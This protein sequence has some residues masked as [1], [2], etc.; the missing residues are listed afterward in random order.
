MLG[1][2]DN[3]KKL[4]ADPKALGRWGEQQAEKL[5]KCKGC[6]ILTRNFTCKAG[7]LD[8]VMVAPDRSIVFVE[9]KTRRS[10]EF[11][12]TEAVI[13]YAK[14]I[15][16]TRAARYLLASLDIQN[17]P[18]RFDVVTIILPERGKVDIRHY[19]SAFV[20]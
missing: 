11:T 17:R 3:R 2:L 8:L 13:T 12:D 4:L 5:L 15:R 9:V 1:L 6:R 10:E 14:K 18:Y 16:M 7:E 19:Q 20:A